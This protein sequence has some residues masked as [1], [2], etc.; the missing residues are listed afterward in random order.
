MGSL[1]YGN[2]IHIREQAKIDAARI[3]QKS[4]N[5]RKAAESALAQFNTARANNRQM[6]AAGKAIN[7]NNENIARN[8]D[9]TTK[10]DI[11]SRIAAAEELGASVAGAAA[12]GVGGSSIDQYNGTLR[13]QQAMNEE[14]QDRATKSDQWAAE[15]GNADTLQNAAAGWDNT[16]YQANMDHTVYVDHQKQGLLGKLFTLGAAAAATAVAGPQAGMAVINL[17]EA[18]QAARNG[19]FGSASQSLNGA[20]NSAFGAWKSTRASGGGGGSGVKLKI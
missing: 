7:A 9:A 20:V 5:E 10:G 14:A 13:L 16:A 11:M 2:A 12:A 6:D 3:T 19:D 4:G 17:N 8:L 18:N 15:Q 1:I